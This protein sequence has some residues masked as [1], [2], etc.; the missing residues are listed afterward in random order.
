MDFQARNPARLDEERRA[1]E[2]AKANVYSL[3]P[4][5]LADEKGLPLATSPVRSEIESQ[6][7][8]PG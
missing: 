3:F 8:H 1:G 5:F 4:E 2:G 6:N 7:S